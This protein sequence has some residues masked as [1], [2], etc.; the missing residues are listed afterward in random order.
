MSYGE[1]PDFDKI[2]MEEYEKVLEI[3]EYKFSE[4]WKDLLSKQINKEEKIELAKKIIKAINS[5]K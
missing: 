2:D 4:C 3:L 1:K 5:P